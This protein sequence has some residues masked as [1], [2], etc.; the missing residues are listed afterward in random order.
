MS[1][2]DLLPQASI[3]R[4]RRPS[5]PIVRTAE[6]ETIDPWTYRWI[7]HR[8]WGPGPSIFWGLLNP[9][10]ADGKRDDPTM[11]RM[12][13]F[14]YRWGFGSMIVGNIYPVVSS[15]P[16]VMRGWRKT[17]DWETYE[18]NGMRSWGMDKTT[19]SAFNH[20]MFVLSKVMTPEMICVAAWGN[21]A[22]EADVHHFLTGV[23]LTDDIPIGML[24]AE[25]DWY[26]LGKNNDG[27]P[28][29]PL[30]RGKN[31]VSDDATL[32]MWKRKTRQS[33]ERSSCL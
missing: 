2:L 23:R 28:I 30:A 11:W 20:N 27:S 31:R 32:Q 16:V 1:Q 19:W 6:L 18:A 10:D 29:H 26:C 22:P 21:G 8:A 25:F 14:S 12:I 3:V 15:K 13:Q 9:S 5:E 4:P 17:W 33:P 7:A 24:G